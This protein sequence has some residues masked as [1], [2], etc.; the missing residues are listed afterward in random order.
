MKHAQKMVMVPEHLLQS[1]ETEHRIDCTSSASHSDTF[2]SRHEGD[3]GLVF[4]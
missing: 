2:R 1:M 4:T 3:H